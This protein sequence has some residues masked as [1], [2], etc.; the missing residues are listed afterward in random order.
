VSGEPASSASGLGPA[1]G[2]KRIALGFALAIAIVAIGVAV[3]G[4]IRSL[5][6]A[7]PPAPAVS[8]GPRAG[9]RLEVAF[10]HLSFDRP[11]GLTTA[12]G[13]TGQL[14]VVE[15]K[16]VVHRFAHSP[17]TATSE[18]FL[19]IHERVSRRGNE[20][21][22]LGLAF[23]PGY[24]KSGV[25]YAY[26]SSNSGGGM[27][28]GRAILARFRRGS[29][30]RGDAK[31]EEVLLEISQPYRN[32]NGGA[33]VFGPDG[34]LYLGL[35]DGGWRAD[36]EANG[37]NLATL[38]GSILRLDVSQPTDYTSPPDNP[39]QGQSGARPE[40]FAYGLRNPWRFSF[41]PQGTLWVG[42]VGQDRW[43]E[44]HT[45]TKGQNC[46][47]RRFEAFE[48]Y[49]DA[50]AAP[51]A[52]DPVFAYGRGEGVSITGGY[53]YRGER[54]PHLKGH[55]LCAD[56]ATGALWA[57]TRDPQATATSTPA[58]ATAKGIRA[59]K[60]LA[61]GPPIASFGEDAAGELYVCAFDGKIYTLA[62]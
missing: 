10:P 35:G 5:T 61:T 34:M 11:V 37:Q 45:V 24:A 14:F 27:L 41:D 49:D 1:G 32:H 58:Y 56:F 15:Q 43:E 2:G 55:Y 20:E 4:G 54:F 6:P 16:G 19:D 40:I 51:G 29:D 33:L 30:G 50:V 36:P 31:S 23:P 9:L 25:F 62:R 3:L 18:V 44:V 13:D 39:F 22:L 48:V 17:E 60:L 42:D 26:Y 59:E 21:G 53:V 52:V 28:G 8:E 7:P 46:G 38:L 47:W 57:L 12:P